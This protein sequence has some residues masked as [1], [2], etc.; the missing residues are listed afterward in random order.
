MQLCFFI[1]QV[2]LKVILFLLTHIYPNG[3]LG[4]WGFGRNS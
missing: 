2:S 1:L 3:V 4:F